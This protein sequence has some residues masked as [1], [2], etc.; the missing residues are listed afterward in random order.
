MPAARCRTLRHERPS[1]V[2]TLLLAAAGLVFF[3][4]FAWMFCSA[5][6]ANREIFRPLQLFP[7]S[8]DGQYFAELFSAKWFP[9]WHVFANSLLVAFVQ[10]AGAVALTSL[11]GYAFARHRF[12]GKR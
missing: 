3:Y 4:P 9:F 5:F 10:A 2:A 6:K 8:L 12:A 11:A 1:F 7:A